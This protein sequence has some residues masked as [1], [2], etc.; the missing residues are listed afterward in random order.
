MTASITDRA[1]SHGDFGASW[2]VGAAKRILNYLRERADAG[3]DR[4][5]FAGLSPRALADVGMTA[6]ERASILGFEEPAR[7]PWAPVVLHRL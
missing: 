3:V 5:R 2:A 7:D 1:H 6:A 4:S